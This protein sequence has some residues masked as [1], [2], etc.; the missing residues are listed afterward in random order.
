MTN[1][2]LTKANLNLK[3]RLGLEHALA[4]A[5]FLHVPDLVL[6]Q[7][8]A[9]F[10]CLLRRYDSPRFVWMMTGLLIRMG[11]AL[12]LHRDGAHLN[13]FTPFEIEMRRRTWWVLCTLDV[14]ASEDQGSDFSIL[15]GS[16]NTKLPLNINDA[17]IEP[18]TAEMPAEREG[19]TDMTFTLVTVETSDITRQMVSPSAKEDAPGIEEQARLLGELHRKLA[20][21]YLQY[22][23]GSGNVAYWVAVT[24]SRLMMAKMTLFIY[25]PTLFSSP[26][27]HFSEKIR[28]KLLVAAI[29]IA[30]CNHALNA[31]EACRHWRWV[32]QTYTRKFD[33]FHS[34]SYLLL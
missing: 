2:G 17:D 34:T 30:E 21:S 3:Y 29:E 10:L 16:F 12:G 25:L 8:F 20:Q 24:V 4:Q 26:N 6:V 9:I 32:F 33:V 14:R 13:N 15:R 5:D 19:F 7:A 31:E 22:P 11:H 18:G 27:E 1:F 23:E 28:T